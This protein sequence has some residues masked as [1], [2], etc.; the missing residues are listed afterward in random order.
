MI[1]S[2]AAFCLYKLIMWL[3]IT[4]PAGA[5]Y[6]CVSD[7][8]ARVAIVWINSQLSS[9]YTGRSTHVSISDKIAH[10][11]A[12]AK[13]RTYSTTAHAA[14]QDP[15]C[16]HK[17]YMHCY[18]ESWRWYIY[19]FNHENSQETGYVLHLCKQRN[20]SLMPNSQ[21]TSLYINSE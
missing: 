14:L 16:P 18:I 2:R 7:S 21:L 11:S 9:G 12:E 15:Q 1:M 5:I 6:Y 8:P 19:C 13:A 20:S 10:L 4:C 3:S 17:C